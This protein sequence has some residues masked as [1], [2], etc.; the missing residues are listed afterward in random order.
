MKIRTCAT[1]QKGLA[2]DGSLCSSS[3]FVQQLLKV[4]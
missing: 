3:K 4:Q 1:G 2:T